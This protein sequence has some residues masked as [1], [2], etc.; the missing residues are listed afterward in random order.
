M[1]LLWI[2]HR[3]FDD[4]CA[5]TPV[6]LSTGLVQCGF[7]LTIINPDANGSH[8][9]FPW[10]H[11]SVL[12]S[13]IKGFHGS[14]FSRRIKKLLPSI[15]S[16]Y[17]GVLV[18]WQVG[19]TVIKALSKAGLRVHLIDRSPP[20]DEGILARLQWKG[21]RNSWRLVNTA[22]V[23]HGFVVSPKHAE[24]VSQHLQ[25][26]SKHIG[27]LPAGISTTEIKT[28]PQKQKNE[29]W[30]FVYHG[31]L[32]RHRGILDFMNSITELN[33][34]GLQC[35]FT[36]IGDGTAVE[37][38]KRHCDS[39]PDLFVYKPSINHDEIYEELGKHHIG[40]LPM[41]EKKVWTLASPLKR[42]EYLASGLMVV[43]L[44]HDGHRLQGVDERWFHLNPKPALTSSIYN[45]FNDMSAEEF[46]IMS[47]GA[48]NYA[49]E[50]L[51]W[52]VSVQT[53][54]SQLRGDMNV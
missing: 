40:V 24:F 16:D 52:D 45:L 22:H 25:I 19:S 48:Q 51:S 8:D 18:D 38:I 28:R 54:V 1:R 39:S 27:I 37:D 30:R 11:I 23:E 12:Q 49:I 14:S 36:L 13:S 26:Q 20:A 3:K 32:D 44:D 47:I 6:A 33:D 50:H 5:T 43:G 35:I 15:T 4:F 29:P 34:I 41:P 53:L 7:D 9:E 2:T 42:G 46:D 31:R 10:T 17:E 21:W